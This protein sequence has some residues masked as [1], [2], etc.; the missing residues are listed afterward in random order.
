MK[1]NNPELYKQFANGYDQRVPEYEITDYAA[2]NVTLCVASPE[3]HE[4][5]IRN[6]RK[7]Y[8][9]YVSDYRQKHG[10]DPK[11]DSY[12]RQNIIAL[13]DN[14]TPGMCLCEKCRAWDPADP[15]FNEHPYWTRKVFPDVSER[16]TALAAVDGG[17]VEGKS[18]SLS[19][20]YARFYLEVQ[21]KAQ[22]YNPDINVFGYAYVNYT[23]PPRNVK[24]NERVIISFVG[25]P[26]FPYTKTQM[27]KARKFWDGWRATGASMCLRPNSP[28]SGHNLPI[29]YAR[30]LGN[31]YRHGYE[32]GMIA[33]DYDSLHGQWSTQGPS[34]YV[35]GRLNVRP[36]L[37]VDEILDEYY[38][39]F[40]PAKDAVKA[41]F[42]HWE[43][44][45]D[46]VTDEQ[47]AQYKTQRPGGGTWR[48]WLLI[49]DLVFT[50]SIMAQGRQ[51]MDQAVVAAGDDAI[52]RQRVAFLQNGFVD[53]DMT[54][55]VLRA[56]I[57]HEQN[58]TPAN[59]KRFNDLKT[60][61]RAF[62][63]SVEK[64]NISDMGYSFYL[65]KYMYKW[66]E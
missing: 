56:Q 14:D 33:V 11:L 8:E 59:L 16:F 9:K 43:K 17:S 64:D 34:L 25:W 22:K 4:Q 15:A 37:T 10:K 23:E 27:D 55:Q 62:R 58:A 2:V 29:S 40:G 61:L 12:A 21:Q 3:L 39:A 38:S 30:S 31:E 57:A 63:H 19:D 18:P 24:L 49:A 51:L 65:E 32:N 47:F 60:R 6:Y 48:R 50:P 13:C 5:I 46:S 1:K 53:A 26:M 54:L 28:H 7:A 41:Y 44:V 20:R 42:E 45:S 35:L 36:D 52:A 66:W